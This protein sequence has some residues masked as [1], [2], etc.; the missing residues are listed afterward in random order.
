MEK[1]VVL[2][3]AGISAESGIKTFRDSGGLWEEYAIEDVATPEAW[4]RNP[5]LV[6]DFYNKRRSQL[7]S[8]EPNIA[9]KSIVALEKKFDVTII[10]QNVDDL[11]ERAGSR[12]VVHLHGELLK[13]RSEKYESLIYDWKKDLFLGDLCEKGT[14]LR[15]HIVWFGELVPMMDKAIA[16]VREADIVIVVGTSM[17]VYPAAGLIH[18]SKW[19][20]RKF[21][22]N[23]DKEV[24]VTNHA[25]IKYIFEN[26]TKGIPVLV[27]ELMNG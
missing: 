4:Q 3:G 12:N 10:T 6:L 24:R 9:H 27:A 16:I 22:V 11:H 13:V 2:S 21:I 5:K 18:A 23:P 1:I 15:P 19:D 25:N 8:V 17:N 14:Q 7:L 20:A 26:A